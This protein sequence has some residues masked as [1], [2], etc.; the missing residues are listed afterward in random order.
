MTPEDSTEYR[1]LHAKMLAS[2]E[3]AAVHMAVASAV[4]DEMVALAER[5]RPVPP[6]IRLDGRRGIRVVSN[7]TSNGA[8]QR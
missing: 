2:L 5:F 4:F 8:D 3:S 7:S 6:V 1:S